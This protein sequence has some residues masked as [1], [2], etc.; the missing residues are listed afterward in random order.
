MADRCDELMGLAGDDTH[1]LLF[2]QD[3]MHSAVG[4]G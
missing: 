3:I 1:T 4:K 2:Y